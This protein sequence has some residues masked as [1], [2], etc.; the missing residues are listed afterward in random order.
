MGLVF[1]SQVHFAL[2][3]PFASRELSPFNEPF[4]FLTPPLQNPTPPL[5][6]F[7]STCG[8]PCVSLGGRNLFSPTMGTSRRHA[9]LQSVN[10]DFLNQ[11]SD[12]KGSSQL[13]ATKN[14]AYRILMV[15]CML[16]R[17]NDRP[18]LLPMEISKYVYAAFFSLFSSL[19]FLYSL[20]Q[21]AV[22]CPPRFFPLQ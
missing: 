1:S 15:C 19:F 16:R 2:L 14:S 21:Q 8:P 12:R 10:G 4:F 9:D 20:Q 11:P 13:D 6:Y 22:G 17:P 5:Q 3:F 7:G 18:T